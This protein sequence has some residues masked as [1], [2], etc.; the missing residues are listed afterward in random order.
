VNCADVMK[1]MAARGHLVEVLCSDER[2]PG[3]NDDAAPVPVRRQ[4]RM[5]WKAEVPWTPRL[6]EQVRIERANQAAL[7]AAIDDL[8]PDVIS[9]WHMAALSLNLLSSVARKNLPIVYAICD[10]WPTYALVMDPWSKRFNL[11][12]P[13]RTAGKVAEAVVGVPAVLP[14]LGAIGHAC[15]VSQFTRDDVQRNSN[16][17]FD[18]SEIIPSGID[19]SE[20]RGAEDL[21]DRP[22]QWKIAYFGRFDARKGTDTLIRSLV[23]LPQESTLVMYGRGGEGERRRLEQLAAD[24]GVQE[25]VTFGTL[26]RSELAAAYRS[27]DCIVFP[28]EWAEPFGLVPLEAMDCGTPVVATGVGG[29]ADFLHDAVNCLLF[30]PG[31][32]DDL[33]RVVGRLATDPELRRRIRGT[34]RDTARSYDVEHM[35]D[36]YEQAFLAAAK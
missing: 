17:S 32:P 31:D 20:L 24:L 36:A 5:Y 3:V 10:A 16:W 11:G 4:L 25:R 30:Q 35:A 14:D 28:S 6:S 19:R 29:S 8:E 1:R 26:N 15:F 27:A 21:E 33:A 23:L 18:A 12:L 13:G 2:L 34:G 9:V 7:D 22:W